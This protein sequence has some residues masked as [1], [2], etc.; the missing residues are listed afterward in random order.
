MSLHPNSAE[1][2]ASSNNSQQT[3]KKGYSDAHRLSPISALNVGVITLHYN[4]CTL[5]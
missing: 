1:S 5:R 3:S 2:E 4:D